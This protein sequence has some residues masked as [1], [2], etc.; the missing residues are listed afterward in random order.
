MFGAGGMLVPGLE[1]DETVA[2]SSFGDY[3]YAKAYGANDGATNSVA[4]ESISKRTGFL[5][6]DREGSSSALDLGQEE[7]FFSDDSSFEEQYQDGEFQINVRAPPGKLG[8]VIDT[9]SGGMPIVH[10]IKDT[11]VLANEVKVGDRLLS[12]DGEDCTGLTAMQVSKLISQRAHNPSRAFVFS[13]NR[14]R[15]T[16]KD[17]V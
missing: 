2:A 8:M 12:V 1:K 16:S 3:E 4:T 5:D 11:S 13:R 17:A 14:A 10:A 7:Q 9:P 6:S 15:L